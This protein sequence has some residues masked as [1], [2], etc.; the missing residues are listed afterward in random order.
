MKK[1]ILIATIIAIVLVTLFAVTT[2][3][4]AEGDTAE[5]VVND[6]FYSWGML[7]TYAGCLAATTVLTQFIKPIWPVKIATQFLSYV[8]ALVVLILANLFIGSLTWET[9]GISVLNAVLIA[10]AAN[11][12]YN[13]IIAFKDTAKG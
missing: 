2:V 1:I 6:S 11:G 9:A 12:T 4:A 3:F 10:L 7:A 8:I 13:N 5:G